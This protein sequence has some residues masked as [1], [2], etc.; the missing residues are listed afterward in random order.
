MNGNEIKKILVKDSSTLTIYKYVGEYIKEDEHLITI[1]DRKLGEIS[2]PKSQI[3]LI[4]N[5][6]DNTTIRDN[7]FKNDSKRN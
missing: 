4:T 6:D 7:S 2:L 5:Y 1:N 3:I